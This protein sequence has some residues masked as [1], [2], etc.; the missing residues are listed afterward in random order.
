MDRK[1]ELE[2]EIEGA[3]AREAADIKSRCVE[4]VLG[5]GSNKVAGLGNLFRG[6]KVLP[7]LESPATFDQL[8]YSEDELTAARA[9]IG[10]TPDPT[11]AELREKLESLAAIDDIKNHRLA[12]VEQI[13]RMGGS[14]TDV[15]RL[16]KYYQPLIADDHESQRVLAGLTDLFV[17][18]I[19]K[20]KNE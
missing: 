19:E 15:Q 10:N 1:Q 7:N 6:S 4:T 17:G 8:D 14:P 3:K 13:A 5:Y 16:K 12:L 20:S 11:P 2:Q 9:R 18:K